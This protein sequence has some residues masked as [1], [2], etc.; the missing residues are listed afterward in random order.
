MSAETPIWSPE[1]SSV[2]WVRSADGKYHVLLKRSDGSDAEKRIWST[3]E[4]IHL[5]AWAP[6][7]RSMLLNAAHGQRQAWS[8]SHCNRNQRPTIP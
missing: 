4:H 8:K 5:N 6:D 2:A 3:D 1:G 7:G